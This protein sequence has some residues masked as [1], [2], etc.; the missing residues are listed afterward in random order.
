MAR[1]LETNVT[2]IL[3]GKRLFIVVA[4]SK[5]FYRLWRRSAKLRPV[6]VP[7]IRVR[8]CRSSFDF[9][10]KCPEYPETVDF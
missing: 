5:P 9:I 8:G 6:I 4:I 1:T 3:T 10:E 2:H 7:D